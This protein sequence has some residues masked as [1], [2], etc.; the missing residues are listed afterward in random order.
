M[1]ISF[2]VFRMRASSFLSSPFSSPWPDPSS[3]VLSKIDFGV[4]LVDLFKWLDVRDTFLH[5]NFASA[6][7]LARQCEHPDAMWLASIFE[8]KDV[9]TKMQVGKVLLSQPDDARA[10]CF[11]WWLSDDEDS[12]LLCRAVEMDYAFARST[13]GRNLFDQG[14]E[15]TY[16]FAKAAAA[17]GER[18]GFY[19]LG[20]CFHSGVGVAKD[21]SLAKENYLI[22]AEL[23]D[24]DAAV[25]LAHL[26]VESDCARWIWLGRGASRGSPFSFLDSFSDQVE[27]FFSG[28]GQASVVLAIGHALK[29]EVDMG[30]RQLFGTNYRY[31]FCVG[32]ANQAVSFYNC[33][34][35]AAR[36]A[37]DAWM[38]VAIRVGI[39]KDMRVCI[40]K[41]IWE[42]RFEANYAIEVVPRTSSSPLASKHLF[43]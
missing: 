35:K 6:L 15:E 26:L 2:L 16:C 42:A 30:K 17:R 20:R 21:L 3:P 5:E 33:Q 11:A 9:S 25:D 4:P 12:L 24:D 10:L 29:G 14:K 36:H 18:D 39:I 41:M 23:G 37:V 38:L 27:R 28:A 1:K 19:L 32:S 7:A 8:G 31:T 40:G 13:L 43:K 22:A 34:I